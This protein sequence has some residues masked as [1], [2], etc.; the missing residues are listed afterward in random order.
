[1]AVPMSKAVMV[2]CL[3]AVPLFAEVSDAE[4][5]AVTELA[6]SLV[7]RKGG[8]LFDEGAEADACFVLTGG[9]A[10]VV[11]MSGDGTEVLLD[12]IRPTSLVGELALLDHAA[13]SAS[14][15]AAED[16]HVIRLPARAFETL[17]NNVRFEQGLVA[18]VTA[19]LRETNDQVR[20]LT[21]TSKAR[22]AWCLGRIARHEGRWEGSWLAIARPPHT[23][24]AEM[25]GCSRETVSRA[26]SAL[27]VKKYVTWD[28]EVMR[29]DVDALQ[30]YLKTDL[31]VR[32][33]GA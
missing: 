31:R 30:R 7:I 20:A 15:I 16:C 32:R 17:R 21:F 9:T 29:L 11:L 24:L 13:R 28:D 8:R 1:M 3:R 19:T 2:Q 27:K 4:L 14:V 5:N 6:R 18:H 10:R 23:A 26:L 25:S 12:L 22:V 33:P